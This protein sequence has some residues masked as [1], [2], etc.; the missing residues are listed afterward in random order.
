[1]SKY[2]A[3]KTQHPDGTWFDSKKEAKRYA[4]LLILERA[5][6]IT[7]LEL[8]PRY[9]MILNGV[10]ICSYSAD[11]R[12]QDGL[13]LVVEDVKGYKTPVYNLKKKM[14]RAFHAIE[15]FET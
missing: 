4:E 1:M 2:K 9:D 3:I 7:N 6:E 11:F 13:K 10:K 14:M 15:I 8:Q 5:Y 12:Y